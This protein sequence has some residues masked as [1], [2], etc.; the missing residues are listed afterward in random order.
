MFW[1]GTIPVSIVFHTDGCLE[2][3]K[4]NGKFLNC[5]PKKWSCLLIRAGFHYK[6]F[7]KKILVF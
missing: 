2:E 7:T 3:V 6:T 4:N 5:H 1:G